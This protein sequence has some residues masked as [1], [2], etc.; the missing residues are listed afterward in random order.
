MSGLINYDYVE[1]AISAFN[2]HV[3]EP[4][5]ISLETVEGHGFSAGFH[6]YPWVA[7]D[8]IKAT[9]VLLKGWNAGWKAACERDQKAEAAKRLA[10]KSEK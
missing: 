4:N 10:E 2:D 1:V 9:P 7:P 3:L 8:V 6:G 5:E